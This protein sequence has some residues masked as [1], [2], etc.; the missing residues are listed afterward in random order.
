MILYNVTV[1]VEED[2]L[3]DWLAWMKDVHIPEVMETGMFLQSEMWKV[4]TT[5]DTGFTYSIQYRLNSMADY[6]TYIAMHA[7]AL[8][9]KHIARYGDKAVAFRTILQFI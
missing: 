7:P 2:I 1:N 6:N 3:T 5:E 4:M 8:Q 9:Q